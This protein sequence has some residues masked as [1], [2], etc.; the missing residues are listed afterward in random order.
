MKNISEP[1]YLGGLLPEK[2][3][4]FINYFNHQAQ[5][6]ADEVYVRYYVEKNGGGFSSFT[7]G[8][9]NHLSTHLACKWSSCIETTE[10][11][12]LLFDHSTDLLLSML[13]IFKLRIPVLIL[14][15]RNSKAAISNLLLATK[16][17]LLISSDKYKQVAKDAASNIKGCRA[18][19]FSEYDLRHLEKQPLNRQLLSVLDGEF[20][21]QDLD[22]ISLILHR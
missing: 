2:W 19:S 4:A 13:A 3:N 12:A 10:T 14:S 22:K 1:F 15:P 8:Q 11:A 21:H 17:K 5:H 9:I 18:F 20:R 7:Y 6:Y 16:S